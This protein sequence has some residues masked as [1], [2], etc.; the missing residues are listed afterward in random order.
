MSNGG[1][2]LI[3]KPSGPTSHDVIAQL[4]RTGAL[5]GEKVGHAGT[6][7]PFATGLLTVLAGQA[8]RYQ[9][10]LTGLGKL[11]ETT[12]CFGAKSDTG[13]REGGIELVGGETSRAELERALPAFNG[14]IEQR[15][16]AYSAVKVDGERLYKKA[17]RGERVDLPVRQVQIEQIEIAQFDAAGQTATLKIRC[18]SG[19]YI[20]QLASDIGESLGVGA[21]CQELRR[22]A[23]GTFNVAAAITL[24]Q[25]LE[26]KE[27][28][29]TTA[30]LPL[31]VRLGDTLIA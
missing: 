7:D 24:E 25:A 2:L 4:R 17:R 13:D 10:C 30:W 21:Y 27:V 18:S 28:N 20:R 31:E 12:L 19:T 11:Y 29:T 9:D 23:V 8:T 16:P 3:D 5:R 26:L 14:E 15:A 1:C 22:L 6:L